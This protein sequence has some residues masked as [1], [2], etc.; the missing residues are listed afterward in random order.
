MDKIVTAEVKALR[1]ALNNSETLEEFDSKAGE[2]YA[3]HKSF[4]ARHLDGLMGDNM[5][6][7][8]SSHLIDSIRQL[9]SAILEGKEKVSE[10]LDSWQT[11]RSEVIAGE[12]AAK[13]L[14]ALKNAAS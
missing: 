8:L 2:F 3:N 1:R 10:L 7:Y 9:Q 6:D 11:N 13:M 14:E 5:G 12:H 4:M